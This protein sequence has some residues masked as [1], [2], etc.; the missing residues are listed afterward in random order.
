MCPRCGNPDS[1]AH[2]YWSECAHQIPD[3]RGY[4]ANTACM[5]PFILGSRNPVID[6]F[7]LGEWFAHE[8]LWARGILPWSCTGAACR[9]APHLGVEHGAFSELRA[10]LIAS[11]VMEQGVRVTYRASSPELAQALGPCT[12][13]LSPTPSARRLSVIRGTNSPALAHHRTA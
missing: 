12:S 11:G 3:P 8:C 6:A 2:R 13:I 4:V 7:I 1:T 9:H 5:A 10:P